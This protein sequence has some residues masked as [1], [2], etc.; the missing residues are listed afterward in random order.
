[1]PSWK[2][3]ITSG[4][5]V[6]FGKVTATGAI[7][8]SAIS[9]SGQVYVDYLRVQTPSATSNEVL[10]EW[11]VGS[12]QKAKLDEDG[13]LQ[14]DG[15]LYASTVSAGDVSLNSGFI[16]IERTGT[17]GDDAMVYVNSQGA[18]VEQ[19]YIKVDEDGTAMF[20]VGGEG[21]GNGGDYVNLHTNTALRNAKYIST[22]GASS[23]VDIQGTTDATSANGDNGALRVE[24]GAS[25]V[26]K[27]YVG[28]DIISTGTSKVISG[29]ASS[30]GS[31]GQIRVGGGVFTS[32]SLAAGGG[33][34]GGS[35][36]N[37]TL[38][39]DGGSN[40]TIADGNTLDIAGGTNIT[41]AVGATDT[42]TVNLDAS[43]SIT[44]LSATGNI[45]SSADLNLGYKPD[46]GS[47]ISA[48]SDGTIEMSGSGASAIL[49]VEGAIT[50]SAISSSGALFGTDLTLTGAVNVAAGASAVGD[51]ILIIDADDS[52]KIK[53]EALTDVVTLL[54]GTGLS[55]SSNKFAVDASQTQITS[56]GTLN[57]GDISSGFGDIDNGTSTLNTGNATV[58]NFTNNSTVAASSIT[59]SVTGSF[60][61]NGANLHTV[62]AKYVTITDNENTNEDNAIVFTAGGDVDG[63]NLGLESDGDLTYNPSTGTLTTTVVKA[64]TNKFEK[65]G[66]TDAEHQGD[67]VF[68]GGTTSM[69]A[70]KIYH[71][72][73]DG[74]WELANADD[75]STADGLLAVAL[76]AASDTNG[77]LLR[78]M[79][80]LDHDN[81]NL[82]DVLYVQSD[83]AGTPGEATATKPAVSGDIVR[84]IGYCLDASNG[85]VWFNPDNTFVEVA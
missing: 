15:G 17:G 54:A 9:A 81:A 19:E 41:T 6:A 16:E 70:G 61:G 33:G 22:T 13:D 71:Y 60:T 78:G 45:S 36:N 23:Y 74:T 37:F 8:A 65:T 12:T 18:S 67:V 3:V 30:T 69:D 42:V 66:N 44:N 72:K 47:Y 4:S 59:G 43:P 14:I 46:A 57:V 79:V 35:M 11:Y 20:T 27:V 10:Q 77:M 76:G 58:D 56:V 83:N 48:S 1:M 28:S 52:D 40:Q 53:K 82:G 80:T 34:G 2:K 21:D 25:I 84:V 75:V 5:D 50:A 31:F 73:S 85:Q 38:T 49:N 29:S 68:L 7:T 62:T 55:N 51:S 64:T 24:G 32:A 39:A 26:G 63:G